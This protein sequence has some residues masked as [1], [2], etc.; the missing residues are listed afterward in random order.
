VTK[1]CPM[2]KRI[3]QKDD[4]PKN[5]LPIPTTLKLKKLKKKLKKNLTNGRE[6]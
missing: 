4:R 3:F 5:N 1:G 2:D 6:Y